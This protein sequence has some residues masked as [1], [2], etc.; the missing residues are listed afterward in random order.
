MNSPDLD[1]L[2]QAVQDARRIL[3]EFDGLN[4]SDAAETVVRSWIET[5]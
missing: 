2:S 3:G 1:A 4:S 5:S